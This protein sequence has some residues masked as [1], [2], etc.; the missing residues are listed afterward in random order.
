MQTIIV[1]KYKHR[2]SRIYFILYYAE[3]SLGDRETAFVFNIII[4][5]D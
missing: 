2:Y 5:L 1:H 3:V 4:Q